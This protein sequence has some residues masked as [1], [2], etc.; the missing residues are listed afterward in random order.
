MKYLPFRGLVV[1]QECADV[2]K[3]G[4]II[5]NSCCM[6]SS[7]RK[8]GLRQNLLATAAELHIFDCIEAG[9]KNLLE[10]TVHSHSY[11]SCSL[12]SSLIHSLEEGLE[13]GGINSNTNPARPTPETITCM[14]VLTRAILYTLPLFHSFL[15]TVLR[16][17][18]SFSF[19]KE[20]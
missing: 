9:N 1:T 18:T 20:N 10:R 17:I 5:Q 6:L 2:N 14:C 15:M 12:R 11:H 13:R 19:R 3:F 8:A 4:T 16:C 7:P